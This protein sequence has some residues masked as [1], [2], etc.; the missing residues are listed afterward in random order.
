MNN[1]I[2]QELLQLDGVED[3]LQ[4]SDKKDM[5]KLQQ[6]GMIEDKDTKQFSDDLKQYRKKHCPAPQPQ[7]VRGRKKDTGCSSSSSHIIIANEKFPRLLPLRQRL[8]QPR[9]Q[10]STP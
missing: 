7:G 1:D 10:C 8:Q 2:L 4:D 9:L 5:Q 6:D 3:C